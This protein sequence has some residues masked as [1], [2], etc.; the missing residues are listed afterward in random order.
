M[1]LGEEQRGSLALGDAGKRSLE[2]AGVDAVL[3]RGE[4]VDALADSLTRFAPSEICELARSQDVV[5]RA[6]ANEALALFPTSVLVSLLSDP[7]DSEIGR[8]A[9]RRQAVLRRTTRRP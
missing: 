2:V 6:L 8:D 9:L 5:V 1:D 4:R 3:L 7:V